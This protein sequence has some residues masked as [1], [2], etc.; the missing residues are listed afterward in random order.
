MAKPISAEIKKQIIELYLSGISITKL[1]KQINISEPTITK[2]LKK[3]NVEIRKTNGCELGLDIRLINKLYDEGS[4]TYEL[5]KRFNCNDETIRRYIKQIRSVSDRNVQTSETIE[6]IR[7]SCKRLWDDEEYVQNVKKGQKEWLKTFVPIKGR[8]PSPLTED[9]K[10]RISESVKKR[11]EDK[12]LNDPE[13]LE[14]YRIKCVESNKKHQEKTILD[15]KNDFIEKSKFVHDN[16]YDYSKIIYIN[17]FAKVE[18]ICQKHGSFWQWPCSHIDNHGCPICFGTFKKTT[19]QFIKEAA[20]KHDNKYDYSK[21]IYHNNKNKVEIICP[22]HGSF[23]QRPDSHICKKFGCPKCPSVISE[24]HQNVL[25]MLPINI[26]IVNNDKIILNGTEIDILLKDYNIGI[27]IN[28][29]YWHGLRFDNGKRHESLTKTHHKKASLAQKIGIKLL[30]FW[31]FEIKN[32]PELIKSMINNSIG[33]SNKIFARKC[34]I[35]KLNDSMARE[36]FDKSHLQG[37]R[38]AGVIY[39][40]VINDEIQCA[41]SFSRH[42]DHEWEIMRFACKIGINVIGGF[43]RL[44]RHFIKENNPKHILTFADRRISIGNLY[45]K[46]GFKQISTTKPNY[47]YWKNNIILSRQK[48]QKRKLHKLLGDSFRVELSETE[49]MLLNGFSKIYDAGHVKLIMEL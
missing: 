11:F 16:K 35:I 14:K 15:R 3:A 37:H 21:V 39:G 23:W 25:D 46:T 40:L 28:G 44:L 4:S 24:L 1:A 42:P 45:I 20:E 30:Q 22:K 43:S 32:K 36:F 41:A 10:R 19:D 2:V 33:L 29:G 48:C 5:A 7:E 13:F 12:K 8:K 18:I 38:S 49:N 9:G 34:E 47:F 17:S 26:T 27:E 6:K 31:D